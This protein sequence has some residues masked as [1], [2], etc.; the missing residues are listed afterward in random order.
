MS[1]FKVGDKVTVQDSRHGHGFK[2]GEELVIRKV[3]EI[4][5]YGEEYHAMNAAGETW[6]IYGDEGIKSIKT[7]KT[8]NMLEKFLNLFDTEP[9]L[10]LKKAGFMDE[11]GIATEDGVKV[12]F[13]YMMNTLKEEDEFFT[14]IVKPLAEAKEKKD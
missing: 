1:K 5:S 2:R 7:N 11:K 13:T 4:G 12:Y 3:L 8:T 9:K 14:K 6:Y 10:S